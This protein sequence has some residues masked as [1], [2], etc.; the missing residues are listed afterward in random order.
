MA[1]V[2]FYD[3]ETTGLHPSKNAI[4]Q[5]SGSICIDGEERESFN[6]HVRPHQG[7]LVEDQALEVAGI[8][9]QQLLTYPTAQEVYKR[10]I[11]LLSKYVDRYDRTDKF[12]LAGY[13]NAA[14]DNRFLS[15]FFLQ[16][17][18]LYFGAWFWSGS[19]DVMILAAQYLMQQ[20]AQMP[21]F[22]LATVAEYLGI[23]IDEQHLHDAGYDIYLTMEVYKRITQP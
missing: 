21:N 14:F 6:F 20:R 7:A 19:L 4:H 15:A 9:R 22:K 12:F 11:G 13:N 17:G 1:K 3:L 10:F 8:T 16:N 2:L 23:A 18:D 5:L